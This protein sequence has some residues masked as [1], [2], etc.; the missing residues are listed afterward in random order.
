M[1]DPEYSHQKLKGARLQCAM[2]ETV[3][4]PHDSERIGLQVSVAGP[5]G[6]VVSVPLTMPR[7]LRLPLVHFLL[8]GGVLFWAD[9]WRRPADAPVAT[10]EP[11]TV[12]AARIR[13]LRE[14]FT[15]TTGLPVT[16]DD[17]RALVAREIDDE[18]LYR[19]ALARGL[20]HGDRSVR[21]Q[22]A[23]KMRF[24]TAHDEP[25]GD[26]EALVAR[27][28]AL[29]LDRDDPVIRRML[30]EKVRLL[31]KA[32]VASAPPGAADLEAYLARHADRY[33]Q[34][35]RVSL[36]HVFV[37]RRAGRA[38]EAEAGQ[39]LERLRRHALPPAEAAALGDGFPL[40]S[41]LRAQ[42]ERQLAA[43]F[44]PGFAAAVMTTTPGAW[45]GPIASAHGVHL[46][47]VEE[48]EPGQLPPLALVRAPVTE[49]LW[50]EQATA[51]LGELVAR[52]RRETAVRVEWPIAGGS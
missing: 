18:L 10:R 19:E 9:G 35:D 30:I 50:R 39:L 12:T 14:E 47:R 40:G 48:V 24:L 13:V 25:G 43:V 29:G 45:S 32:A 16:P 2:G 7:W 6:T 49:A 15:R 17:E 31:V 23:E 37:A 41:H 1:Q 28:R 20:D 52:L 38:L 36:W 27:A 11:V 42:S 33:R 21:W 44:G 51:R 3:S 8:L 5:S 34:P 22:L 46:V 4:A 26:T